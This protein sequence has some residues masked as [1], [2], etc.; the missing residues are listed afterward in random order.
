[1]D[2]GINIGILFW[3]HALIVLYLVTK[4]DVLTLEEA[5]P[6][7]DCDGLRAEPEPD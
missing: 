3:I 6:A 1:M 2:H 5:G 4:V 7:R